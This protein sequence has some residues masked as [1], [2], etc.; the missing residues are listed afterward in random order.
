MLS[1]FCIWHSVFSKII[2]LNNYFVDIL[3]FL[4]SQV[5]YAY[6]V[7]YVMSYTVIGFFVFMFSMIL[8][9]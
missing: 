4:L 2:F 6:N 5:K 1:V 9:Q 7:Y 3:F 8:G